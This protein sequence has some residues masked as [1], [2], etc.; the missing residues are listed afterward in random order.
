MDIRAHAR[1]A[2]AHG[3]GSGP[4]EWVGG[5]PKEV[6]AILTRTAFIQNF[7]AEEG[8]NAPDFKTTVLHL[9]G[10]EWFMEGIAAHADRW[11]LSMNAE[12]AGYEWSAFT[13]LNTD[14]SRDAYLHET[15]PFTI[16]LSP[17]SPVPQP[18]SFTHYGLVAQH[19]PFTI[20][21][22][23]KGD[24]CLFLQT[25]H[26]SPKQQKTGVPPKTDKRPIPFMEK[27]AAS[28]CG[29]HAINNVFGKALLSHAEMDVV[30]Q[31]VAAEA[32]VEFAGEMGD[33]QG[34]YNIDVLARALA[35]VA[36]KHVPLGQIALEW[37]SSQRQAQ[38]FPTDAE[39]SPSHRGKDIITWMRCWMEPTS[40]D[41]LIGLI[42]RTGR[43]GGHYI[44]VKPAADLFHF[45][46]LDSLDSTPRYLT[47]EGLAPRLHTTEVFF[48]LRSTP[49]EVRQTME[50]LLA[51]MAQRTPDP[52]KNTVI[53]PN[54]PKTATSRTKSGAQNLKH[55]PSAGPAKSQSTDDQPATVDKKHGTGCG[56]CRSLPAL[57]GR[58][59]CRWG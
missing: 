49:P 3:K 41:E 58:D 48:V 29:R 50:G 24:D 11:N 25:S 6:A 9:T 44:A 19:P 27:Q 39:F 59:L 38:A 13:P 4:T 7:A 17:H 40:P 47:P 2:V 12:R 57:T 42:V 26:L 36:A 46:W 35:L 55:Q 23:T 51:G 32:P 56:T 53:N 8:M 34:N 18:P 43:S 14:F 15:H 54:V 45:W 37:Y 52:N 16:P 22:P 1:A 28:R 21:G 5:I 33:S 31:E 20:Q 30:L 10:L